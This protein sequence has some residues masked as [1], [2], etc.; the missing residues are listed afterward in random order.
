MLPCVLH[1]EKRVGVKMCSLHLS[2]GLSALEKSGTKIEILMNTRIFG[3]L[4]QPSQWFFPFEEKKEDGAP[5]CLVVGEV[6]MNTTCVC[7]MVGI[8]DLVI[9]AFLLEVKDVSLVAELKLATYHYREAIEILRKISE[10]NKQEVS[11]KK[12]QWD[13]A[14]TDEDRASI[15]FGRHHYLSSELTSF[16]RHIDIWWCLHIHHYGRDMCTNYGHNLS[17]DHVHYCMDKYGFLSK[18]SHQYHEATS[19]LMKSLF[20]RRTQLGVF[21]STTEERSKLRP[22]ARWVQR[23]L[24]WLYGERDKGF[25]CDSEDIMPT[26]DDNGSGNDDCDVG[27]SSDVGD[28]N[29]LFYYMFAMTI[30]SAED[31]VAY[32]AVAKDG[33]HDSL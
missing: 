14:K 7:N 4:A 15:S 19:A 33:A 27:L 31:G 8:M 20:F 24:M 16:Q 10:I 30:D 21:V 5:A 32:G 12:N 29:N 11:L 1:L 22:L 25:A 3:T 28:D 13:N 6:R 17:A 9:D 2:Y 23:L 26:Y 18:Y